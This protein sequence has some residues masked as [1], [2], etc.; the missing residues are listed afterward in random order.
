MP[1]LQEGD[2]QDQMLSKELLKSFLIHLTILESLIFK[3]KQILKDCLF[4]VIEKEGVVNNNKILFGL[5]KE[6]LLL[7]KQL[8]SQGVSYR[9]SSIPEGFEARLTKELDVICHQGFV[10]YFLINWD[11]LS[12][13]RSKGYFYVGRG[14]GANSLVAY[15]L[16]ITDVDPLEL[17]LY[18]ERFINIYRKNPPDF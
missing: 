15:L 4:N 11:I 6:D 10:S 14:S 9:Y 8:C 16:R 17:D 12:Y 18:F 3:S 1:L 5:P 7:L 2:L 13:A